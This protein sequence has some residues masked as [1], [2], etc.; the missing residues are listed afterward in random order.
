[1][2]SPYLPLTPSAAEMLPLLPNPLFL[3]L[4]IALAEDEKK[5]CEI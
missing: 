2:T 1:M 5:C 3:T 4:R